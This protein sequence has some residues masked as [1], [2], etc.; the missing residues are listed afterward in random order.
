MKL[1][2]NKNV[3]T[4]V[5]LVFLIGLLIKPL[6]LQDNIYLISFTLYKGSGSITLYFNTVKEI[7]LQIIF[8][9]SLQCRNIVSTFSSAIIYL[10]YIHTLLYVKVPVNNK[11]YFAIF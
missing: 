1:H 9:E 11:K 7:L 4:E 3:T 2:R 8:N 5:L 10:P 6:C